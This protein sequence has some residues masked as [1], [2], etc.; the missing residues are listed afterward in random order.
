MQI[1]LKQLRFF[2]FHGLYPGERK[3]GNQFEVNIDISFTPPAIP[4]VH[5]NQTINYAEVYELVF[6]RMSIATPLLE[7]VATEIA[8]EILAQFSLA[9]SIHISID[10][11]SPPIEKFE[12]KVGVSFTLNRSNHA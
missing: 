6:R 5:I 10:K 1:H 4:V 3:T 7:T 9:D 12:G 8:L 2:A 11:L